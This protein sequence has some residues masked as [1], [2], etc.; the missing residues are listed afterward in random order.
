MF[1]N[2]VVIH[3]SNELSC[4]QRIGVWINEAPNCDH[5]L[6]TM[7]CSIPHPGYKMPR[8]ANHGESTKL[9]DLPF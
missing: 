1:E 5:D 2:D 7:W 9:T 8:S 6:L 4:F 3:L